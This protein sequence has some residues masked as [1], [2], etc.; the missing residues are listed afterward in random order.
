MWPVCAI[1]TCYSAAA[2]CHAFGL[3]NVEYSMV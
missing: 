2:A 1:N 3:E